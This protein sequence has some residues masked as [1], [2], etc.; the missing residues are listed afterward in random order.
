M[1]ATENAQQT[2]LLTPAELALCVRL[3]REMRQ[4]SQEQLAAISGLNV[5]TIQRVEHGMSASLDTRRAIARA[6]EFEDI[7]ALNKPFNIP[8]EAEL[9]AA[10]EKFDREHVNLTAIPLTTG[11][12]LA[13][14]AETC[15]MD[16]SE[17]A[18]ELTREADETFAALVDY[19]RDYRDC[20]DAY[21]ETQKFEVYDEMQSHIDAL[22]KLGVSL[23][24]AE[25]KMQ[26][27]WGSAPDSKPMPANV[28]YVVGFP[29]GK[30]PEQFATPRTAGIWL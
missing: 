30:E 22:K 24:Y 27:K 15:T 3:F 20:A 2:R 10:K 19:F 7:D 25:R 11:K 17:P 14:L 8:S 29:L 5:R 13:K 18:F 6:F 23:R 4:W 21:S 16:L 12:Q 26:M 9:K 1:N 28:L